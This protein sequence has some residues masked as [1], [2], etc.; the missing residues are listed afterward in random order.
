MRP[1]KNRNQ[2]N[3]K[4]AILDR[5]PVSRPTVARDFYTLSIE[6]ASQRIR[7]ENPYFVPTTSI[8]KAIQKA[9]KQ[10]VLV[11]IMVPEKSDIPLHLMQCYTSYINFTRKEPL[12][13]M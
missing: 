7:I 3:T 10:G 13:C 9:L 2:T 12:F 4:V 5:A 11:E 1:I 8:Y 6:G